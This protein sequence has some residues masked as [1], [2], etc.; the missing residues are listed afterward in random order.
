VDEIN[1]HACMYVS[2][3]H[4]LG[5]KIPGIGC[6]MFQSTDKEIV[7]VVEVAGSSFPSVEI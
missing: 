4:V 1:A 6:R 3:I 2:H 7:D 5:K